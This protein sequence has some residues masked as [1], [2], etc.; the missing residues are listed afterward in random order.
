MLRKN[1]DL[2]PSNALKSERALSLAVEFSDD[3]L[4]EDIKTLWRPENAAARFLPFIAWGLHLDFW[5]DD[6]PEEIKRSLI[7]SSFAWH[8]KKGTLW[9]IRTML[10]YL[11]FIPTIKEWPELGTRAHTFSVTGYYKDDPSNLSFLGPE[12]EKILID[13]LYMAKPERSHLIFL[14][15]APPPIDLS[16]H[17]CR[18]DWC[19]WDHGEP[20]NYIWPTS[21]PLEGIL[22]AVGE[23]GVT[24]T[25]AM[26][27]SYT[28]ED[29]WDVE[30]W[31]YGRHRNMRDQI[32]AIYWTAL[33]GE[34]EDYHPDH[35]WHEHRDWECDGTWEE[36]CEEIGGI[37]AFF[38]GDE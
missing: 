36:S 18:W 33:F 17:I 25:R 27:G 3:I 22:D 29:R 30:L 8:R 26:R 10:G 38:E 20:R 4:P 1:L 31:D 6:L 11:G 28:R 23:I 32:A 12:T 21:V 7:L 2:L 13:A 19:R 15:V 35:T 37:G 24:I 16:D 34:W 5:R 14:V 9:A